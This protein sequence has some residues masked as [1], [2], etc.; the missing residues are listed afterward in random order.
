MAR[1][2]SGGGHRAIAQIAYNQLDDATRQKVFALLKNQPTYQHHF[3]GAMPTNL[4]QV[5]QA[6]WTFGEIAE[7]PDSVRAVPYTAYHHESWHYINKPLFL[8]TSDKEAMEDSLDVNLK[9]LWSPTTAGET[10]NAAQTIDWARRTLRSQHECATAKAEAL[11]WL[12]HDVGD[13]HQPL[14]CVAM[15]SERTFPDGDR[16]GNSILFKETTTTNTLHSFW[17][18]LFTESDAV[19]TIISQ[20]T[21][22]TNDANAMAAAKTLGSDTRV[23]TWLTEAMGVATTNVYTAPILKALQAFDAGKSNADKAF[24]PMT[25]DEVTAYKTQAEAIARV[26]AALAGY[27]LAAI[28]K[29]DL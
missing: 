13:L 14:H 18:K 1:A 12:F 24:V 23:K 5:Q 27:R 17:D 3:V 16:G 15:F 19:S 26:R 9:T 29:Q 6:L 11:C 25:A 7:W 4:T 20:V 22:I 8:A 2:W 10:Q 21:A 28:L